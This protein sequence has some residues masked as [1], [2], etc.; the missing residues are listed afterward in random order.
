MSNAAGGHFADKHRGRLLKIF[1]HFC[2]DY[3]D[4]MTEA[5]VAGQEADS[6]AV[7]SS[8]ERSKALHGTPV[9][10]REKEASAS[11]SAS[12]R[13]GQ[14]ATGEEDTTRAHF[15]REAKHGAAAK[16]LNPGHDSVRK[17]ALAKSV[18]GASTSDRGQGAGGSGAKAGGKK[19]IVTVAAN[20]ASLGGVEEGPGY[21][22]FNDLM[23]LAD[24]MGLYSP[25]LNV[26]KV[27]GMSDLLRT[28]NL[29]AFPFSLETLSWFATKVGFRAVRS[30]LIQ[31]R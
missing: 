28:N 27:R 13:S 24:K 16:T 26:S 19:G 22:T 5:H 6:A 7:R 8:A 20:V 18:N 12:G 29:D 3:A 25:Q 9:F 2:T 31:R 15:E 21:M 10:D 1:R 14:H 11:A 17:G 4:A 23:R 30:H